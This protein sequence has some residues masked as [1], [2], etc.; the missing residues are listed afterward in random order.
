MA[1]CAEIMNAFSI[2]TTRPRAF[3]DDHGIYWGLLGAVAENI[4]TTEEACNRRA[5]II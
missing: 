3:S 5:K 1:N 4:C 2:Y